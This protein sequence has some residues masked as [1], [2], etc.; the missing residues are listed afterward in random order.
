MTSADAGRGFFVV[1]GL[2][3]V[4]LSST[5]LLKIG[6]INSVD[7]AGDSVVVVVVIA[8]DSS[9]DVTTASVIITVDS[10]DVSIGLTEVE[11]GSV[12]DIDSTESTVVS[13]DGTV[14]DSVDVNVDSVGTITDS[15]FVTTNS[16]EARISSD[17][18]GSTIGQ[19]EVVIN[20]V[21]S[22]I[23]SVEV[24]VA[25]VVTADSVEVKTDCV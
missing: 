23:D 5:R 4:S 21:V 13:M 25:S 17:D 16:L 12:D 6:K 2:L 10:T 15:L 14:V 1:R 22:G 7:V 9:V 3:M 8:V 18:V 24:T 19:L 20:W 11:V